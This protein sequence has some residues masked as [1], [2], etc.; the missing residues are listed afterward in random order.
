MGLWKHSSARIRVFAVACTKVTRYVVS[1]PYWCIIS[2]IKEF[3]FSG[4]I[5]GSWI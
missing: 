3:V 4:G 5:H 2:R 1:F